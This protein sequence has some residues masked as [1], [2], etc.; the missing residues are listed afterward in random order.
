[1]MHGSFVYA[2]SRLC[3]ASAEALRIK[4]V[5]FESLKKAARDVEIAQRARASEQH[6]HER[7]E[8]RQVFQTIPRGFR[9]GLH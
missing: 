8:D 1:M 2:K 3:I 5:A 7:I 9:L 4:R 6:E